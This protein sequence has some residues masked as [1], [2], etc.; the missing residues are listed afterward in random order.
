[1]K[2]FVKWAGGKK[3]ILS[4]IKQKIFESA[5]NS[6]NEY[7]FIEPFVGGGVVFLSLKHDK[8]II[9]DLNKELITAYRVIRNNPVELMQQLDLMFE[10]FNLN[11]EDYYK[12][13]RAEDREEGYPNF[14]DIHIASRMIFLNKTC[15]NGLYR[16]NSEGYFNTPMGRNKLCG[17]YDKKNLQQVSR[18]L[19]K[20]P[21]ENIM[22]GS[23]KHAMRRASVGDIVYIDP[24]YDY[25]END[26]F[27]KY[28]KEGFSFE[29][30]LE[31]KEECDRCLDNEA[32]VIMSN[33][34]TKKVRD[35][36]KNDGTHNYTFYYI[37]KLDTKRM[38]NCKGSLRNTGKEI[39]V[40]GVPCGFPKTKEI[41]KT[42]EY[43]RVQKTDILKDE[44]KLIKRFR[45]SK[46]TIANVFATL[47]Y[48]GIVDALGNMTSDGM[49]V[50]KARKSDA[51]RVMRDIILKKEVFNKVYNEDIK[52]TAH[53]LSKEE[54]AEILMNDK[55]GLRRNMA[56][57][58]ANIVEG[59]IDWCIAN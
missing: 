43:I 50:R 35:T 2:P 21:E 6:K 19:N 49:L 37:E 34:D 8:T 16:V 22:N 55:P 54:I 36:F 29:D 9:N 38:I 26:G 1:M 33:N 57:V 3:Q 58:R 59:I 10:Q 24:P 39:I 12:A 31:L 5:R 18:Y 17:F 25:T 42:I 23:Y 53:K 51:K 28:Q 4:L 30:L 41:D 20:L 40:C 14:D 15:F 47:R 45:V 32:Y 46:I 56:M 7:T 27:T 44:Q 11:G 48:F 13:I 52:D